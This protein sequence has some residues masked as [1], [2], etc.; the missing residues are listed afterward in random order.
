MVRLNSA[1]FKI[2]SLGVGIGNSFFTTV[3]L[4][5]ITKVELSGNKCSFTY[6]LFI[7]S[8]STVNKSLATYST[9]E[10]I[11]SAHASS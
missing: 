6:Y 1:I 2:C 7:I 9:I 4:F 3:Q 8:F 10:I 11:N 5:E